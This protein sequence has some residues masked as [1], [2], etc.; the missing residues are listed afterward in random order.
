MYFGLTK[1]VYCTKYNDSLIFLDINQNK[2]HVLSSQHLKH[3]HELFAMTLGKNTDEHLQLKPFHKLIQNLT[4]L[5]ILS[6]FEN[7]SIL[8]FTKL[9]FNSDGISNTRWWIPIGKID[10]NIKIPKLCFL[11]AFFYLARVHLL[12]KYRGMKVLFEQLEKSISHVKRDICPKGFEQ[13]IQYYVRALK[14]ASFFSQKKQNVSN[15]HLVLLGC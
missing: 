1:G 12:V 9:E 4:D 5:K 2:Y 8:D 11:K 3:L 7:P 6:K 10:E 15:G 13:L 14:Y